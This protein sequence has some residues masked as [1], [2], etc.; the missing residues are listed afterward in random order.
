MNA[1]KE[2][3]GAEVVERRRN[4]TGDAQAVLEREFE[5][6]VRVNYSAADT[7][8]V[9]DRARFA[10]PADDI[11]GVILDVC[12]LHTFQCHLEVYFSEAAVDVANVA[13]HAVMHALAYPRQC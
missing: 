9:Y 12:R 1:A 11:D 7:A 6:A 3:C 5:P 8:V 2:Y 4:C 10:F 13:Y